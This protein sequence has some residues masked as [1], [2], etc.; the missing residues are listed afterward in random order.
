MRDTA[1][2][3]ELLDDGK[4]A[5]VRQ[6]DGMTPLMIASANGDNDIVGLLL[7]KGAD[8]NLRAAGGTS[9]LSLARARGNAGTDTV[10]MLQGAGA[11]D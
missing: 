2:V 11:K 8:P 6:K 3:K 1:G 4:F 10:R 5:N 7:A 9:A